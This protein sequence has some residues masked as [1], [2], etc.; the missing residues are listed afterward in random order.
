M[1]ARALAR[2][3]ALQCVCVVGLRDGSAHQ[4]VVDDEHPALGRLRFGQVQ[5]L[6]VL[7]LGGVEED[8]VERTVEIVDHVEGIAVNDLDPIGDAGAPQEL[9]GLHHPADVAL[10]RDDPPAPELLRHVERRIADRG[11]HLEHELGVEC[12]HERREEAARLPVHDRDALA[13]GQLLHL[14]HHRRALGSQLVQ[15]ALDVLGEDRHSE[16]A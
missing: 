12:P 10:D 9:P 14:A 1:K 11:A 15:V 5:I 3:S 16:A 8:H 13:L 2:F 4:H 7:G 6:L